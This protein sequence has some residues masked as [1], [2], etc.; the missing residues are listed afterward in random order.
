MHLLG[1]LLLFFALGASTTPIPYTPRLDLKKPFNPPDEG[2]KHVTGDVLSTARSA[3][4]SWFDFHLLRKVERICE[5]ATG[6]PTASDLVDEASPFTT[7]VRG[8]LRRGFPKSTPHYLPK[9]LVS[10]LDKDNNSGF[11][12]RHSDTPPPTP[13]LIKFHQ[14]TNEAY[15]VCE[16]ATGEPTSSDIL[17]DA[18]PY[19]KCTNAYMAQRG[20][21]K[22]TPRYLPK[23]RNGPIYQSRTWNDTPLRTPEMTKLQ[24]LNHEASKVCE[25]VTGR[26]TLEETVDDASPYRKCT[27][28]YIAHRDFPEPA[29]N[30]QQKSPIHPLLDK[31]GSL[32]DGLP[33]ISNEKTE[34]KSPSQEQIDQLFDRTKRICDK[35]V[36]QP[37][38]IF[39]PFDKVFRYQLIP[40]YDCIEEHMMRGAGSV[41]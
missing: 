30:P 40:Y 21:P 2:N 25:K 15:N 37:K 13:D 1:P 27:E 5:Q 32:A 36:P 41:W 7:C 26:P 22:S 38:I 34:S 18:S 19:K 31:R 12:S 28:G 23:D 9:D 11:G 39:N 24:Q 20:F 33:V 14:V 35:I 4:S 8:Y 17:D 3:P 29:P 6:H 10:P 16:K